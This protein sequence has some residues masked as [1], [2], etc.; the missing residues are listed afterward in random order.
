M[1]RTSARQVWVLLCWLLRDA[2]RIAVRGG[3]DYQRVENDEQVKKQRR[4]GSVR[5]QECNQIHMELTSDALNDGEDDCRHI[6]K[7]RR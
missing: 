2:I 3:I 5:A 7:S 6:G 1:G 4:G